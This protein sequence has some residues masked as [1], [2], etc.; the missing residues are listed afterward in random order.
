MT[1][2]RHIPRPA[3]GSDDAGAVACVRLEG[4][5]KQAIETGRSRLMLAGACFAVAFAAI[6]LRLAD[7]AIVGP[8]SAGRAAADRPATAARADIVDRNGIVL[9]TSLP[10][11]SLY[12]DPARVLDAE[13]AARELAAALP[14]ID[15]RTALARL[16]AER[17]FVWLRRH[18]TP[19]QYYEVN[20]LGIP[21][22]YFRRE[23]RR[24]YPNGRLAAHVL[25]F[26][27]VDNHGLAGIE[28]SFDRRL[29]A[30]GGPL[31]LS[32]DIR[33][34]DALR[35]ELAA[36]KARYRALGAAGLVLDARN[37]EVLAMVSLPDFDPNKPTAAPKANRFNRNTLGVYE[38]GS[39]FKI[40][41]V[42]MAL[43]SGAVRLTDRYFVGKP[44]RAARFLIR[45]HTP[46]KGSLTVP[47]IFVHSSNI[48]AVQLA[49]AV[50]TR[51]QQEFLDR[52]GLLRPARIELPEIGAPLVPSPWREINTMTIAFGHGL[53]VS[54]LQL[55]AGVAAVV[56]GGELV[57]TTVLKRRPGEAVA[58][59]RV[60]GPRNST[61][62]RRLMRLV[63]ERGTGRRAAVAGYRIGGKT[64]S[65]DK[66][67][68]HGPKKGLIS[69]FVGAFPIDAPRYVVLVLL[70]EPRGTKETYFHA[71]GGWVAAP[72]VGRIIARIGPLLKVPPALREDDGPAVPVVRATHRSG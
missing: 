24:V 72:A 29:E 67:T 46:R 23:E 18:L 9:A 40:F 41:T 62:M 22:L 44:I 14:D 58:A 30:G 61:R 60:L 65:A 32:L 11:Y 26:T 59:R 70:D 20:R 57:P 71:T 4:A 31:A 56:N 48:G 38:M 7:V 45:D 25:G 8:E 39:T 54:P 6:G 10:T 55:A 63:V 52:L 47:E 53:A 50:G 17:R 66:S 36:A 27:D 13:A 43:E 15:R 37:G 35:Q 19:R 68:G 3:Y 21:G 12:A 16:R 69:S 5:A 28:R 64:G 34:A 42:A 1:C 51:G 49:L 2:V 33:V